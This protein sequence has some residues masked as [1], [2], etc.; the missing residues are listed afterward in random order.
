MNKNIQLYFFRGSNFKNLGDELGWYILN[1]LTGYEISW[2]NP[3]TKNAVFSVGSIL[4]S[5]TDESQI[6]W[7]S[8]FISERASLKCMPNITSVRGPLTSLKLD[9]DRVPVGDPALLLPDVYAGAA[10][11]KKFSLGIIPHYIDQEFVKENLKPDADISY[12]LLNI[13]HSHIEKFIDEILKCEMVVSSTLHGLIIAQAYGVPALWVE[14]SDNVIGGG[15]KF[16]DYFYSVGI[17]AYKAPIISKDNCKLSHLH[18]LVH[19]SKLH[20]NIVN[21]SKFGLYDSLNHVVKII[22]NIE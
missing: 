6:V 3:D 18:S 4:S 7:G 16:Y 20:L 9:L 2:T 13:A 5:V 10:S 17:P 21:F 11:A 1:K 19:N 15:Y 8:G 14:F 12:T 22:N